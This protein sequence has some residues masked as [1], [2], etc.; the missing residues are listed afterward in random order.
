MGIMQYEVLFRVECLHEY[1]G[2]AC[3]S[4][5]LSPTED[6]RQMLDRY[7][8][9]FQS[10]REGGAVYCLKQ[11]PPDLLRRFDE[12]AAF[13]FALTSSD[14]ALDNYTDLDGNRADPTEN[15]YYFDNTVDHQSEALGKQRR[16]LHPYGKPLGN[17]ALPVRPKLFG[18]TPTSKL[19]EGHLRVLEPLSRQVVWQCPYQRKNAPVRLDLRRV[20]EGRYSLYLND[21]SLISFFLTDRT[22]S[23][24]WG[25]VSI[26]AGGPQ[27]AGH[28]P[29][30][31]RVIDGAGVVQSKTFSLA[32]T[33]RKTFWRYYIIDSGGKQ[34][35]SHYELTAESSKLPSQ[36]RAADNAVSFSLMPEAAPV[37]GHP[38]WVFESKAPL[39]LLLSPGDELSLSLR[40][41]KNGRKRERAIR[42]PYAQPG[43]MV[44]KEGTEPRQFCSEIF[45]YV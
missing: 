44:I 17:A 5:H 35:F 30:N 1:F 36:G 40:P 14:P 37:H 3:R 32:L 41:G 6:C 13:T 21:E 22:P 12:A 39:P 19:E 9:L 16:L 31:C 34:D 33:S 38:T 43:S 28:L 20:P 18:F 26:Y 10:T 8:M 45:V 11:S 24:L 27:E 15:I 25:A 7:R 23:R 42:L 4:L 2:G 29:E